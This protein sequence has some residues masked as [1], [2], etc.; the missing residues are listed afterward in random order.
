MGR[1]GEIWGD[2]WSTTCTPPNEKTAR[3][4]LRTPSGMKTAP[5]H[6]ARSQATTTTTTTTTKYHYY[7]Y[8]YY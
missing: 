2:T 5:A 1:D 4:S 8:Y 6:T 7:Y 3:P